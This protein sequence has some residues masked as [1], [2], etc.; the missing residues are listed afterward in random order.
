M[1]YDVAVIGNDEA[2]FEML[3]LSALG[4]RRTLAILPEMRHS[5]FLMSLAMRRLVT[6]LLVERSPARCRLLHAAANPRLLRSMLTRAVAEETHEQVRRLQSLGVHVIVGEA[7]FL[8]PRELEVMSGTGNCRQ[9]VSARNVVIATGTMQTS[10]RATPG[11]GTSQRPES[12]FHGAAFPRELEVV[13]HGDFAAGL[14]A[15]VSLLGVR[16]HLRTR[17]D[18]TSAVQELARIAGVRFLDSR[19]TNDTVE[20]DRKVIDC[21]RDVGF[22]RHLNLGQIGI[23]ADENEQLWCSAGLETWCPGIYGIGHVVGFHTGGNARPLRQARLIF[24]AIV[25]S[26]PRP[27]FLGRARRL[28]PVTSRTAP[29][30]RRRGGLA[31]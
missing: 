17:D 8:S 18:A 14:A 6:E 12:L 25:D 29:T 15:I 24:E 7:K 10:L 5:A 27:H 11:F 23:Q 2:A 13:G 9:Q 16:T 21:R 4:H 19:R 22:T 28:Q 20:G 31:G 1:K 3:S 30:R 26:I